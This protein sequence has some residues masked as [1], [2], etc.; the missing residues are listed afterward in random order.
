LNSFLSFT[1]FIPPEF[2][3]LLA[4]LLVWM[5]GVDLAG[6]NIGPAF[7]QRSFT[8]GVVLFLLFGIVYQQINVSARVA[9]TL[10]FSFG[11]LAMSS[12]RISIISRLRSGKHTPFNQQWLVG[13]GATV[14][15]V[16]GLSAFVTLLASEP[17]VIALWQFLNGL[18]DIFVGLVFIL[19]VIPLSIFLEALL[20]IGD[21]IHLTALLDSLSKLAQLLLNFAQRL[22][23]PAPL[24]GR[25]Q[26]PYLRPI[27]LTG[28]LLVIFITVI[29]IWRV[30]GASH[31]PVDENPEGN[32]E[33]SD[34]AWQ[35]RTSWRRNLESLAGRLGEL[36][37]FK[38]ARR[39]LAA[40]RIRRIY[41]SLMELSESL[42]HPR[43]ASRT[44][45]EFFPVL[46]Q[47]FPDEKQ[48]LRMITEAYLRVRYGELPETI[49]DLDELE[50]AWR[51]VFLQGRILLAKM[52]K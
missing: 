43:P 52:K 16:I 7:A 45:L 17:L 49:E 10:F 23:G 28:I 8:V 51:K 20:K 2:I 38:K 32:F 25:L 18:K 41:A 19:I 35:I 47:L 40:A 9:M 4:V 42:D 44:P 36:L 24:G 39:T 30:R 37:G 33:Q 15:A 31:F 12:A 48:D 50:K 34:L 5:R 21:W 6:E 1:D 22:F 46:V 29:L 26:I 11:L 3:V 27:L 14:L 13:L